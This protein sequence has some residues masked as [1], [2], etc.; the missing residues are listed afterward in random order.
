LVRVVHSSSV[1][2]ADAAATF[3]SR[4]ATD[5]VPGIGRITGDRRS[6]QARANSRE[7]G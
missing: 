2:R 7:G 4:W 3:S 1:S 5:G 6:G